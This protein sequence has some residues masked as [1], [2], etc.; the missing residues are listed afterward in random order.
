ML[1]HCAFLVFKILNN[2]L[3]KINQCLYTCMYNGPYWMQNVICCGPALSRKFRSANQRNAL[4]VG[5][6]THEWSQIICN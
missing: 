3:Y 5:W 6:V 2:W 1:K 4:K